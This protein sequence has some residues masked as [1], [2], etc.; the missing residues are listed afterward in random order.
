M[1]LLREGISRPHL[2]SWGDLPDD[3]KVL[4]EERPA[5]LVMREFVRVFEIWQVF[6]V[7]ENGDRMEGALQVLFPFPQGKDDSEKLLIIDIIVLF[8]GREGLGE[9][10][11]RVE[12][13]RGIWLHQNHASCEKRGICHE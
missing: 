3:V 1:V 2:H 8:C 12:V 9:V 10:S 11:A 4:E 13:T 7:S 5:S 6:M